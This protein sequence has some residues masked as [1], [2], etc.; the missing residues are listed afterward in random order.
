MF[1]DQRSFKLFLWLLVLYGFVVTACGFPG[2]E[3]DSM[4]TAPALIQTPIH[5]VSEQ[6]DT[7]ALSGSP[8]PTVVPSNTVNPSP[9]HTNP[10]QPTSTSTKIINLN[11]ASRVEQV[12]QINIP[13]PTY[14]DFSPDG[15]TIAIATQSGSIF[16][17]DFQEDTV[18]P[19]PDHHL[20]WVYQVKFSPDGQY[21]ASASQDGTV[22]LW[23]VRDLDL[24]AMVSGS[25]EGEFSAIAFHPFADVLVA[26]GQGY[27]MIAWS[28]PDL[29]ELWHQVGT[30][31]HWVW[32]M[33]YS[34]DGNYLAR[35][36]ASDR[37]YTREI[38]DPNEFPGRPRGYIGHQDA[39]WSVAFSPDSRVLA[40][41]SWDGTLRTWSITSRNL[42][43]VYIGHTDWVYSVEFSPDGDLLASASADKTIRIW[44]TRTGGE[45]TTITGHNARIWSVTFSPDGQY[46]VSA[47]DDSTVRVWT[48]EP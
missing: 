41:G 3:A 20:G 28:V 9:T 31:Y 29:Q 33:D 23:D 38:V 18:I 35:G 5:R 34:P 22:G 19:L 47:S 1:S 6:V 32:D 13:G 16:L 12:M 25:R 14:V 2:V 24:I 36:T 48:V 11:S 10:P 17:W 39:V 27:D 40:T 26:G 21:L 7:A 37:A 30:S 15:Q 45:I 43:H 42:W 4:Q 44:E 46:L 8:T